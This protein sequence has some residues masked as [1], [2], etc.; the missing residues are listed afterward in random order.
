ME[1]VTFRQPKMSRY[2]SSQ[3]HSALQLARDQ[4]PLRTR[5]LSG[6]LDERATAFFFRQYMLSVQVHPGAGGKRGVYEFLPLLVQQEG[7][8]G[9]LQTVISACGLAALANAGKAAEW[10]TQAYG[11][12]TKAIGQLKVNL[13]D[14]KARVSDQTLA[15]I[16][17]MGTFEVR[18]T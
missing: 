11:M 16:M 18:K 1:D 14:A 9:L 15:A 5:E 4:T 12:L 2:S 8:S 13:Q 10:Q 7:K 17:L 6:A 3:S